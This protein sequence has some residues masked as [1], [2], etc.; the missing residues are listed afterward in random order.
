M[1]MLFVLFKIFEWAMLAS[2]NSKT[3]KLKY[4]QNPVRRHEYKKL[5]GSFES[6]NSADLSKKSHKPC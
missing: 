4:P 5:F 6:N 3:N 1:L 2:I